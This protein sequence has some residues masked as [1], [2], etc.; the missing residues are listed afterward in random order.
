M[1]ELGEVL[2]R[3]EFGIEA[4]AERLAEFVALFDRFQVLG[5]ELAAH[6]QP[7]LALVVQH[8]SESACDFAENAAVE[9]SRF[10]VILDGAFE[11][12]DVEIGDGVVFVARVANPPGML[13]KRMRHSQSLNR[14]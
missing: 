14:V 5:A 10:A 2:G 3:L 12:R 1:L 8:G 6:H 13:A 7:H 11:G 9:K 4:L